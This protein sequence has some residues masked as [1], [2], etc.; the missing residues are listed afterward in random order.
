MKKLY[1]IVLMA[2]ALLIGTNAKAESVASWDALRSALED[3]GEVTLSQ[4]I[5]VAYDATT[6]KSILIGAKN[7]AGTALAVDGT[8]P[9]A[10]TL[11]LAGHN[12]TIT[13]NSAVAINPFVL[14][15]GSLEVTGTGTIE[16][17]GTTGTTK[18]H[19]G[20]TVATGYPTSSTNVFFVFG[21]D[22]NNKV[23]PK[24][25]NPFSKL[26]IGKDVTVKTK[27]GTVIAIDQLTASHAALTKTDFAGKGYATSGMAYGA[28]VDVKGTLIS[29]GADYFV[30]KTLKSKINSKVDSLDA[31]GNKI[32]YEDGKKCYGVKVN[33][34]VTLPADAADK[35]YTPYV[36]VEPSAV[37]R[38]DM[39]S[40][41][42]GATAIY[43]SGFGQWLIEGN[44]S[45][46]SGVYISSGIVAINDATVKSAADTYIVA[47]SG[48]HANGSGSAIVINSRDSRSGDVEVTVSG[49]TKA[50]STSGYALEEIV[51]TKNDNTKVEEIKI[52][53]GSF[54]GG[55]QG[56]L[57]V[58]ASTVQDATVVV[59]GGNVEGDGTIGADNL[60]GYLNKQGNTHA[61]LVEDENGNTVLVISEGSAPTGYPTVAGHDGESV[62]WNGASETL[63][64]GLELA[65]LEINEASAQVLN[66]G[67][68]DHKVT[69]KI[70]R[71]VLGANAQ[72]VVNPG[73][74]LIVNGEQGFVAASPNNF[75]LKTEEG[76]PAIFL[77]HPNVTSNRHPSA[78]V[79][80]ISKS[81]RAAD[82]SSLAWQR[83][84][85]PSF[86]ALTEITA[87]AP[88]AFAA[89]NYENNAWE[90]I[91]LVGSMDYSQMAN[92]FDYYQMLN[93]TP[94]MGTVV[95]MKGQLYGNESPALSV[96]G[97]FW[98][99][100]ANSYMA[101]IDGAQLIDMIPNTVD[102]AFYLNVIT[103][104]QAIWKSVTLL[105][106]RLGKISIQP[107]QAFLIRN[108]KEAADVLVDYADAVYY[109][110][111]GSGE[112]KP[113]AAPA[114][115]RAL[116]DI[117]IARL[118]VSGENNTDEVVVAEGAEFT[119]EFDNGY[120]AAKYMNDGINMYVSANE[121]MSNFATDDLN[122]TYVGLQTVNGGNYTIEFADVQG[123][124]LVLIDHETGARVAMVEG[125]TYEF[126]ANGTNDY[127]FE[128][129]GVAKLPTA[130]ENAEAVKSAKG[131]YTIT[132]QYVGEM[133]VWNALPAGVYVVN[134]EKRVK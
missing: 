91:G 112:T 119:A 102:K 111:A 106:I 126:T 51:N 125:A 8:A 109:T 35:I 3:G 34:N 62:K 18:D 50:E 129:V 97:N 82:G 33:G 96:R 6:F 16:V 80:F 123:E 121:K 40:G 19:T 9:A 78:T 76:N 132:G 114:P 21:G 7:S 28:F 38:A 103:E 29:E 37:I 32:Y 65:E 45:G 107:M 52:E 108:T 39:R 54:N 94:D 113:G 115:R 79:A 130:I 30:E 13:A 5:N 86:G 48:T 43:A 23:D 116:N 124:E 70:G 67:D 87:T 83:F 2:A 1:S 131:V 100:F 133:N 134:G 85:I 128:I 73:S 117:T 98:N 4:D 15:K 42:A 58:T 92:S 122:N 47:G 81:W 89:F 14:T 56:A 68:A 10:A 105:N 60:A 44:C 49:D 26:V 104:N 12:I 17:T 84:G 88:T 57:V 72:V 31:Q 127:R 22:A 46:A 24:G 118:V 93:N 120:D 71:L 36:Y 61:T 95:T 101:P 75:L 110:P 66:I 90:N 25:T 74:K 69:V 77:F 59:N 41:L 11:D 27:N 99:G 55:T 63:S 53:G 64:D 20:A